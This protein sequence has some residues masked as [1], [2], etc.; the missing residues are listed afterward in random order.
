MP[1]L[2][3]IESNQIPLTP[4]SVEGVRSLFEGFC[5]IAET[6]ERG[7]PASA[8]IAVTPSVM[9]LLKHFCGDD[10]RFGRVAANLWVVSRE[11][12]KAHHVREEQE[13]RP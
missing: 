13:A 2:N 12:I 8:A 3:R 7:A 9:E 10:P 5:A 1:A 11:N 4:T 6:I